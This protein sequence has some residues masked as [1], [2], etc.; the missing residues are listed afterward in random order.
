MKKLF[1]RFFVAYKQE[2]FLVFVAVIIALIS[3]PLFTYFYFSRDLTSKETIMNRNNTGVILLDRNNKPFFTFYSGKVTTVVPLSE[4]P[5]HIQAAVIAAE[6]KHFY[7]HPGISLSAIIRSL[8]LDI[9]HREIKYGG[10]TITQQL[11]KNS[12]LTP[13]KSFLRKYQ[14]VVLAREIEKRYTKEEILEM[15]LNSVYF[16]EGAFGIQAASE[17]YFGKRVQDLTLAESALLTGILPSPSEYSP[18]NGNDTIAKKRQGIVLSRMESAGFI[19]GEEKNRAEKAKLV[20]SSAPDDINKAAP[21]FA[22]MVRQELIKRYGEERIS[23]SGFTVRTTLDLSWQAY[24]EEVVSDQVKKLARNKVTN[25][26]AVVIDP[27]TGEIKALVGSKDWYD[28]SFGKVNIATAKRPPGSSFKPLVYASAFEKRVITPASALSDRPTTFAGNYR[29]QDYDRRYRGIVLARRALANS[30]NIPAVE[31]LAKIGVPSALEIAQRMG[32]T[33]LKD[34]SSYG[35]SLVLGTGEV[36]L[37]ELTNAYGIFANEGR[38]N[39][40]TSILAITDKRGKQVYQYKPKSEQVIEPEV[41]FLISSI[42]SDNAARAE[43]FGNSLTVSFPAAVKT[44][45]TEDYRDAWTIGYTP[46]LVVG[47]WVGNNDNTPMDRIAGSLGA[48]P[49][50]RLL[51]ERFSQRLPR[52]EF[53]VPSGITMLSVCRNN[54]FFLRSGIGGGSREYFLTGTGPTH[55]CRPVKPVASQISPT[56]GQEEQK[57]QEANPAPDGPELESLKQ[58]KKE[59]KEEFGKDDKE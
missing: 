40:P 1:S 19:S 50:W 22:I 28:S 31:V 39:E 23:R 49:I 41:A 58:L 52:S 35:L 7:S 44:G 24:A 12:L 34:P 47:V 46:D 8:I 16:G 9:Q 25:G 56:P 45:T 48:A 6:D 5:E 17:T 54:G 18:L 32:I 42:L 59:L 36:S 33:T 29:P 38:K 2:F 51:M 13:A 55:V 21:H 14:E 20:Y 53:S 10:S 4:I 43:I 37:L 27:K 26:A 11:V 30:L 15:Y 3:V 57:K